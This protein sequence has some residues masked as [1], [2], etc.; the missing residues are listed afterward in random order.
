MSYS[1]N[2]GLPKILINFKSMAATA[3]IRS[4]RGTVVMILNDSQSRNED[5]VVYFN[6]TEAGDIPNLDDSNV[7]LL[8]KGL[9]G[10]PKN[11]LAYV[12][13]NETYTET[14]TTTATQTVETTVTVQPTQEAGAGE[15]TDSG[16]GSSLDDDDDEPQIMT[17]TTTIT[18]TT[19]STATIEA[20]VTAADALKQIR[21]IPFNWI[22]HPTGGAQAQEDLASWVISQRKNKNKTFKAVVAHYAADHEGVVNFTTENIKVV[23]PAYTDALAEVGNDEELVD[24]S[25]QKYLR[26]T[27]TQYTARIAG[28]LAGLS[29]D[30]SATYF[31]LPEIVTCARYSDIDSH[32]NNGEFCLLDEHEGM[33]V[34]IARGINSLTTFTAEHGTD[35]RF[36]KVIESI[37][38]ISD[39][40]R[41]TFREDY[42]GKVL[43]TYTNKKLFISAI[44]SYFKQLESE[45]ILDNSDSDSNF[46]E[47]DEQAQIDFIKSK[48]EDPSDW[49][50]SRILQYNTG[51]HVFL[52][53]RV[54]V[55]NAMEDLQVNFVL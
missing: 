40:I 43:N 9:L 33:G 22:C 6:I 47:I 18:T 17:T 21:D 34:K 25:I 35:F 20:T 14:I 4:S 45:G 15:G 49:T 29:L 5:G 50:T 28:L 38:L 16:D 8:K 11:I 39:D 10:A 53:G 51:T 19:T 41:R 36:I 55:S 42:V 3:M 54:H 2:I 23:N 52:S 31:Q 1:S 26:Y 37:D 7:D 48:G 30:R 13:P 27:A 44:L 32:I 24:A 46:V 12:I